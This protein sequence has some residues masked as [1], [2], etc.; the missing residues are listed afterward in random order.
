MSSQPRESHVGVINDSEVFDDWCRTERRRLLEQDHRL[1]SD[2]DRLRSIASVDKDNPANYTYQKSLGHLGRIGLR[3]DQLAATNYDPEVAGPV[4]YSC[5]KL[6]V[7]QQVRYA[8]TVA[9]DQSDFNKI[10]ETY[11]TVHPTPRTAIDLGGQYEEMKQEYVSTLDEVTAR[12]ASG[13]DWSLRECASTD[14]ILRG[15]KLSIDMAA[16]V[17]DTTAIYNP[18]DAISLRPPSSDVEEVPLSHP[19]TIRP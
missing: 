11:R 7:G 2:V 6:A 12:A 17:L 9:Y 1:F 4:I 8:Y 18:I 14:L 15:E 10:M 5:L 16:K 13:Q 19:F 3:L